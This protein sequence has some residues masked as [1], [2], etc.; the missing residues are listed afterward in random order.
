MIY[1]DYTEEQLEH[2]LFT[3]K[4]NLRQKNFSRDYQLEQEIFKKSKINVLAYIEGQSYYK[5]KED[6]IKQVIS[7]ALILKTKKDYDSFIELLKVKGDIKSEDSSFITLN[8]LM[9]NSIEIKNNY[10]FYAKKLDEVKEIEPNTTMIQDVFKK[11]NHFTKEE[12]LPEEASIKIIL[13]VNIRDNKDWEAFIVG[14]YEK[15]I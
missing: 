11:I 3:N 2:I 14:T 8:E 9:D 15:S 6:A 12:I 10:F 5:Y 1:T 7:L 13:D 4:D